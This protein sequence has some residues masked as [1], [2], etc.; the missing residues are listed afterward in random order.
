MEVSL[1]LNNISQ[2]RFN[3]NSSQVQNKFVRQNLNQD[4]FTKTIQPR[5]PSFKGLSKLGEKFLPLEKDILEYNK[6][7]S[8]IDIDEVKQILERYSPNAKIKKL[9]E[10]GSNS[11]VHDRTAAYFKDEIL[12]SN[13]G[14]CRNGEKALF[15]KE[16]K[17]D[18][19]EDKIAFLESLMHESTHLFQE[20]SSD[21]VSKF[22]W[23][24]KFTE[25]PQNFQ[26]KIQT[27]SLFPKFFSAVEYNVNLPLAKSLRKTNEIP[28]V[29]PS[30]GEK[31][32][33]NIYRKMTGKD[34]NGFVD[35]II[36]AVGQ[37]MGVPNGR[38][39][40]KKLLEYLAMLSEKEH[41]AYKNQV[42]FAK[43]A[44]D[45]D[46][47]T[48]M[49]LLVKFYEMFNKRCKEVSDNF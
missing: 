24:N 49:D 2:N 29:I 19:K 47:P 40:Q 35:T 25:E 37:H 21:R 13:D 11:N 48:D 15:L 42:G 8:S 36:N 31:D 26:D 7:K 39:N 20:T 1:F 28:T 44:I 22:S 34:V 23:I 27:L 4:T 9:S 6:T 10:V 14:S 16:P 45:V 41:E 3:K 38:Y 33:N 18:K 46:K 30:A 12:F 32:V 5:T 43:K 17:S